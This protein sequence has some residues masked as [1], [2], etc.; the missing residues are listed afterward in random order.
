[1]LVVLMVDGVGVVVFVTCAYYHNV[2]V[3][4]PQRREAHKISTNERNVQNRAYEPNGMKTK[5]QQQHRLC[6]L[7]FAASEGFR[8]SSQ[9]IQHFIVRNSISSLGSC[10]VFQPNIIRHL[11]EW[12]RWVKHEAN[13]EPSTCLCRCRPLEICTGWVFHRKCA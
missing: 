11:C 7:F 4:I 10:A 8:N 5:T 3:N 1:M 13:K 9:N 6:V 2:I 12:L